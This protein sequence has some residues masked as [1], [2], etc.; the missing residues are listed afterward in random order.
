MRSRTSAGSSSNFRTASICGIGVASH[1]IRNRNSSNACPQPASKLRNR[2]SRRLGWQVG[3]PVFQRHP[4][5]AGHSNQSDRD[6]RH[7]TQGAVTRLRPQ[8]ERH[9]PRGVIDEDLADVRPG[10]STRNDA[11]FFLAATDPFLKHDVVRVSRRTGPAAVA[12]GGGHKWPDPLRRCVDLDL[13]V[14]GEATADGTH[15]AP[16]ATACSASVRR[17]SISSCVQPRSYESRAADR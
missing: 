16:S 3:E 4:G 10:L 7:G 5:S 14:D 8:R 11:A 13:L 1:V 6:C 15:L 12:C 17:R 9:S 2:A